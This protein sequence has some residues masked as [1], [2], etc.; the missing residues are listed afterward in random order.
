MPVAEFDL[1]VPI[2]DILYYELS[3]VECEVLFDNQT[4]LWSED[5]I[6]GT[7]HLKFTFATNL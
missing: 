4:D 6:H 1:L 2:A 5:D 3:V 7:N